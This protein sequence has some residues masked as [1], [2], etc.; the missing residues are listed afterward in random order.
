MQKKT[1]TKLL[2]SYAVITCLLL[3][4]NCTA[5]EFSWPLF[6][7]AIVGG[8]Y[9]ASPNVPTVVPTVISAGRV[10]MDRNL[11][12][13]RVATHS[14]DSIAYG[15]LYQWGRPSDGHQHRNSLTTFVTSST[16]SPGHNK[17]IIARMTATTLDWRNPQNNNLWQGVDGV[18]NPCPQGFRL[19]TKTEWEHEKQSWSSNDAAGAF[20]SPV[21]IVASG[22]RQGNNSADGGGD[23]IFEGFGG[24]YWSSTIYL[25]RNEYL[26]WGLELL[27][28][29]GSPKLNPWN[30]AVGC[31][32]RCVK[33]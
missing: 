25:S 28:V 10:W 15:S 12:A 22:F 8:T 18:N 16:N 1:V 33:K 24:C 14:A 4:K 23:I 26:S 3:S 32:V 29:D 9:E 20:A 30:R 27:S 13:S 6:L 11:G 7:P 31:N 19:P 5:D 21:K 2:A 17:F